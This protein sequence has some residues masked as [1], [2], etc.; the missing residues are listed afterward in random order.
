MK[1]KKSDRYASKKMANEKR[2]KKKTNQ[3]SLVRRARF[4]IIVCTQSLLFKRN[5]PRNPAVTLC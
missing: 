5:G 4:C 2:K 3:R 1:K